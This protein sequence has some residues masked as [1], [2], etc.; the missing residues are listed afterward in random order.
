MHLRSFSEE[1]D[2]EGT[3]RNALLSIVKQKYVTIMVV[4]E[5]RLIG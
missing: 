4:V 1:E 2:L 5:R 3:S